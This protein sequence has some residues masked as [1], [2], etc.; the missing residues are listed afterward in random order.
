MDSIPRLY[1]GAGGGNT[2]VRAMKRSD[3]KVV[4]WEDAAGALVPSP[5][6][7]RVYSTLVCRRR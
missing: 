2:P 6:R 7:G 3:G 4:G 1:G 5:P